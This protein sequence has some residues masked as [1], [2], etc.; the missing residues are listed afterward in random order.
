MMLYFIRL[1]LLFF[2]LEHSQQSFTLALTWIELSARSNFSSSLQA[3]PFLVRAI[4]G[5]LDS[6]I[7]P[8][9]LNNQYDPAQIIRMVTCAAAC[10]RRMPKSRPRM[11]QVVG[12]LEGNH[13]LNEIKE[14]IK[15]EIIHR[16][17]SSVY[18]SAEGEFK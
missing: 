10:T 11:S 3:T 5:D 14:E 6:F 12:M 1:L 17:S 18:V 2:Y 4:D 7:D 15:Q 13:P 16:E 8:R 9:L